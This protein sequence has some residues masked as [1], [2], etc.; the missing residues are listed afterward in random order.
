M[1]VVKP[2]PDE[3]KIL[4]FFY[5]EDETTGLGQLLGLLPRLVEGTS[6]LEHSALQGV[7]WMPR[8]AFPGKNYGSKNV[9]VA[10]PTP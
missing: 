4:S 9:R 2:A 6:A 7:E 3:G 5:H 1:R 10:S 8:M